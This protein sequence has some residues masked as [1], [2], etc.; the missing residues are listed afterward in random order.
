MARGVGISDR[1]S[2]N[3]VA[4]LADTGWHENIVI[5]GQSPDKYVPR[6]LQRLHVATDR[7]GRMCAEHALPL[8]WEGMAY[9]EFLLERRRRMADIIR[10]AFRQLGGEE[11][12]LPLTPPWF[13][14]GAEVVWQRIAE[15]ERALRGVVRDVYMTCFGERAAGRIEAALPE[16]DRMRLGHALRARPQGSEPLSIVDYLYLGQL[17]SLLSST[18]VWQEARLRLGGAQA[19]KRQLRAAVDNIAPVR[20]AIAHVREVPPEVL[21]RASVACTDVL[22][23]LQRKA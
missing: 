23:M 22:N 4:N 13:L 7:W 5:G 1:R 2:I 9:E 8:G 14:P 16:S 17:P 20:N 3:Q 15:T 10:V 21:Q 19:D 12:A 11:G 6:L 18:D